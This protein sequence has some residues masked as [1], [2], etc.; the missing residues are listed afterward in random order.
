MSLRL[1]E[2]AKSWFHSKPE[3]LTM[4]YVSLLAEMKKMF[5]LRPGKVV[6]GRNFEARKWNWMK[7]FR[8]IFITN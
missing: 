5:D 8:T 7:L 4:S 2:R 6:L 1:K 3:H